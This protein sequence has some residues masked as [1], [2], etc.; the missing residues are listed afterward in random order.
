MSSI[1]LSLKNLHD[2]IYALG[3]KRFA[4][5]V[6]T[7]RMLERRRQPISGFSSDDGLDVKFA[8]L[9]G[10]VVGLKSVRSG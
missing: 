10:H 7:G 6:A 8:N 3:N 1:F 2:A 5:F 4:L 9:Q